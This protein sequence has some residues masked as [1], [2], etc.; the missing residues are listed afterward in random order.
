M[1]QGR[2]TNWQDMD[3]DGWGVKLN[4]VDL[5]LYLSMITTI[6]FGA[7]SEF[8]ERVRTEKILNDI[9][10]DWEDLEGFKTFYFMA[11]TIDPDRLLSE[12]QST[13]I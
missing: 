2:E 4:D 7:S 13:S 3:I 1:Q 12:I 8:R 6:L 9:Y 11:S 10:L 5:D